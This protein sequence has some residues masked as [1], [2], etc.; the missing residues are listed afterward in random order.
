MVTAKARDAVA[1]FVQAMTQTERGKQIARWNNSVCARAIGTDVAHAAYVASRINYV[2]RRIKLRAAGPKCRPNVVVIFSD[3]P[4]GFATEFVNRYPAMLGDPDNGVASVDKRNDFLRPR[5]V[6]WLAASQTKG[7]HGVP[8][9]DRLNPIYSASRLVRSTQEDSR[10]ALILVDN[11][12]L[13]DLTW[14]QVSAYLAIVALARPDMSA[15]FTDDTI[16]SLFDQRS[17]GKTMSKDLTQDD[18]ALLTALYATN[19]GS[20]AETQRANIRAAL[21]ARSGPKP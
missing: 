4:T 17:R 16:L 13:H 15:P 14:G 2:A 6:R 18:M 12:Q 3:D 21:K 19:A 9:A 10:F 11:A 20:S 7:P 1:Q 5:P 8:M